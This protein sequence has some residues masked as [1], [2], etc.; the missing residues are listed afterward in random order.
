MDSMRRSYQE[1][2]CVNQ[3]HVVVI[4][5]T[6]SSNDMNKIKIRTNNYKKVYLKLWWEHDDYASDVRPSF[7]RVHFFRNPTVL[8]GV[9][10]HVAVL[11]LLKISGA[12]GYLYHCV[13]VLPSTDVDGSR[14]KGNHIVTEAVYY[15]GSTI[16][17]LYYYFKFCTCK[18]IQQDLLISSPI[19]ILRRQHAETK[20]YV[21]KEFWKTEIKDE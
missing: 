8:V 5:T 11:L 3:L 19:N 1:A 10:N 14:P 6:T 15:R 20:K 9:T 12:R 7:A 17:L 21:C 2:G 4:I 13:L 16:L 18:T